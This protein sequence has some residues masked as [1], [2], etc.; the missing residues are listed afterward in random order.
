MNQDA[1]LAPKASMVSFYGPVRC[2]DSNRAAPD[3]CFHA[4][5]S[6]YPVRLTTWLRGTQA[7]RYPAACAAPDSNRGSI[8]PL[9]WGPEG[10]GAAS[11]TV[12]RQRVKKPPVDAGGFRFCRAQA[13]RPL[14]NS[15]KDAHASRSKSSVVPSAPSLPSFT[16][17]EPEAGRAT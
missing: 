2:A 16:P 5:L 17:T 13:S 1:R 6:L 9:S 12:E 3:D 10:P 15:T 11:S 4:P 14:A 7:G 8:R